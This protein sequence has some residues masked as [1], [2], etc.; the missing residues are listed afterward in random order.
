MQKLS[1]PGLDVDGL[2]FFR[3]V[4]RRFSRLQKNASSGVSTVGKMRVAED[5][6]A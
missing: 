3:A 4:L 5:E 6:N 2:E 1:C